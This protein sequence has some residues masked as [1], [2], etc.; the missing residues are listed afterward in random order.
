MEY[1]NIVPQNVGEL[2]PK[3]LIIIRRQKL[4]PTEIQGFDLIETEDTFKATELREAFKW[5][6]KSPYHLHEFI[7]PIAGASLAGSLNYDPEKGEDLLMLSS[8]QRMGISPKQKEGHYY[9]ETDNLMYF[10]IFYFPPVEH[11]LLFRQSSIFVSLPP[12]GTTPVLHFTFNSGTH[13]E[14]EL[15]IGMTALLKKVTRVTG[16]LLDGIY[17]N[18]H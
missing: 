1:D 15:A 16:N 10:K 6:S 11:M 13:T 9:V 14:E 8:G 3:G 2:E 12:S 7:F 18:P 4:I 17:S 5:A